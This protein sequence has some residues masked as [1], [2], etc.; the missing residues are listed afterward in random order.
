MYTEPLKAPKS[1][2]VQSLSAGMIFFTD[3]TAFKT[4]VI[5][6]ILSLHVF[7]IQPHVVNT[8]LVTS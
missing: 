6:D 8:E 2:L 5:A 1:L 7:Q 4:E 3:F